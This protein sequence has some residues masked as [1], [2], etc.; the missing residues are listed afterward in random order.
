MAVCFINRIKRLFY[1]I[2]Q[3]FS[4]VKKRISYGQSQ[5]FCSLF[6][7]RS[8]LRNIMIVGRIPI[9]FPAL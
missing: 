7:A 2:F 6:R 9:F 1:F 4:C 8:W 3:L 5:I